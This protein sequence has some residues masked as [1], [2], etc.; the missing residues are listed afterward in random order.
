MTHNGSWTFS[1]SLSVDWFKRK[2]RRE[3]WWIFSDKS[4]QTVLSSL[5]CRCSFH[6]IL[7]STHH[8]CCLPIP[9]LHVTFKICNPDHFANYDLGVMS[10]L[11][12]NLKMR[13]LLLAPPYS[14][15]ELSRCR[16]RFDSPAGKRIQPSP[17]EIH[18]EGFIQGLLTTNQQQGRVH[19][20]SVWNKAA[21]FSNEQCTHVDALTSMSSGNNKLNHL[22]N[23]K[24]N[25]DNVHSNVCLAEVVSCQQD[26]YITV[27]PP[28]S[29]TILRIWWTPPNTPSMSMLSNRSWLFRTSPPIN[30]MKHRCNIYGR[31]IS[32]IF[33]NHHSNCSIY[34]IMDKNGHT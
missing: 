9:N 13:A 32:T 22:R 20:L 23:Q 28:I 29:D 30:V 17:P 14:F 2:S 11:T 19:H 4:K 6:P 18:E 10:D 33:Q 3:P 24:D 1:L 5:L 25:Y 26:W 27:I 7:P 16:C 34:I 21:A 31:S 12:G 15:A 8:F